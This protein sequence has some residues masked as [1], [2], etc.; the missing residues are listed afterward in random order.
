MR[1]NGFA[2]RVVAPFV[3]AAVLAGLVAV[4]PAAVAADP[5]IPPEQLSNAL[6]SA[7]IQ[8]KDPG[9][10]YERNLILSAE[11]LDWRA[12]N[13]AAS[14][15]SLDKH[16]AAVEK[17]VGTAIAPAS[18]RDPVPDVFGRSVEALYSIPEVDKGGAQLKG[19]VGALTA[20]DLKSSG[21]PDTLRGVLQQFS[22]TTSE[23]GSRVWAALREAAGR[24][25]TLNSTW[26]TRM[27]TAT[28]ADAAAVDPVAPVDDLKK[29][30]QIRKV[31]DVDAIQDAFKQGTKQGLD[32]LTKQIKPLLKVLGDPNSPNTPLGQAMEWVKKYVDPVTG[33]IIKS[34]EQAQKEFLER[35]KEF[36]GYLDKLKG[37]LMAIATIAKILNS[38]YSKDIVK[39]AE[40]LYAIGKNVV[41]LITAISA[42]TAIGAGATIGSVVPVIGTVIGA[43][44]GLVVT[45]VA[46]LGSGGGGPSPELQAIQAMHKEMRESFTQLKDF[47][48]QFQ[49]QVNVRFDQIDA[50]LNKIYGDMMV[51]FNQ[52]LV[53]IGQSNFELTQEIQTLHGEILGLAATMQSNH[54]QILDSLEDASALPFKEFVKKYIDYATRENHPIPSYGPPGDN[55]KDA[56]EKFS[57][58][59]DTLARSKVFMRQ[60][61]DAAPDDILTTNS[62][63]SSVNYLAKYAATRY[64]TQYLQDYPAEGMP[65][66]EMFAAAARAYALLMDQNGPL[67]AQEPLVTIDEKKTVAR[68]NDMLKAGGDL[69]G[70]ARRFNQPRTRPATGEW[71]ATNSLFSG[72]QADNAAKVADFAN[73]LIRLESDS[74]VMAADRRFNL[75]GDRN[76]HVDGDMKDDIAGVGN[77]VQAK[78]DQ[79]INPMPGFVT[80]DKLPATVRLLKQ[81]NPEIKLTTC[82]S[83]VRSRRD[84]TYQTRRET[85]ITIPCKFSTDPPPGC[86]KTTTDESHKMSE[87]GVEFQIWTQ[88]PGQNRTY[89]ASVVGKAEVEIC[90]YPG[91]PPDDEPW[92]K[93]SWADDSWIGCSLHPDE[94]AKRVA[95]VGYEPVAPMASWGD[96]WL[97]PFLDRQLIERRARYYRLVAGQLNDGKLASAKAIDTNMR[98]VRA[99]SEIAFP[100]ALQTDARL[101]ELLYGTRSLPSSLNTSKILGDASPLTVLFAKAAQNLDAQKD[102]MADQVVFSKAEAPGCTAAPAEVKTAD[103][104]ARCLATVAGL[105]R[106]AFGERIEFYSTDLTHNPAAQDPQTTTALMR[107]LRI[108][109]KATHPD[110][111]VESPGGPAPVP[112]GSLG[113]TVGAVGG[114]SRATLGQTHFFAWQGK[115]DEVLVASS[116]DGKQWWPPVT[117]AGPHASSDAPAI[118]VFKDKLV[119]VWRSGP[120]SWSDGN[121]DRTLAISTS[122]D[123][124]TWTPPSRLVPVTVGS[125]GISLTVLGDKLQLVFRGA[126][127]DGGKYVTSSYD[128]KNWKRPLPAVN[129]GGTS[130]APGVTALGGKLVQLWKGYGTDQRMFSATSVNGLDW[131]DQAVLANAT[132][133]GGPSPVV[134]NGKVFAVWRNG[135]NDG[136]SVSDT[137]DGAAWASPRALHA[138]AH[139]IG[140][141]SLGVV[142]GQLAAIWR[143]GVDGKRVNVSTSA[144]GITWT[145]PAP[146][147]QLSPDA[148]QRAGEALLTEAGKLWNAS[149]REGAIAKAM[150]ALAIAR[151]LAAESPAYEAVVADW[152]RSPISGYLADAG[153]HD[154]S[155]ALLDESITLYRRLA[156]RDPQNVQFKVNEADSTVWQGVRVWN[157]GDKEKG[158]DRSVEGLNLARTLVPKGPGPAAVFAQ[159]ARWP[160]SGFLADT[161]QHDQAIAVLGEAI[162]TYQNLIRQEP[163]NVQYKLNQADATIWQGVRIWNK[164]DKDKG[165]DRSVEGINLARPLISTGPGPA[166]AFAQWARSPVS[167][168]LADTGRHDEAI[169]LLGEAMTAYQKLIQQDP[170]NLQHKVNLADATIWQGIRTWNKGDHPLGLTRVL[171]GIKLARQ[172]APSG[173]VFSAHL[174]AW[175]LSPAVD[176]AEASGKHDDAI[177]MAKEAVDI[178]TRL[179]ESD[180][181]TYA[182]PLATAKQKLK[183]L[184]G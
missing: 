155:I 184:Q 83:D 133:D 148:R 60:A 10:V 134:F 117:I 1:G 6:F 56:A 159:W 169:A 114:S 177:A 156:E 49:K 67:A 142:G 130:A 152:I 28:T 75:W 61:T 116:V 22:A 158:R 82:W 92:A 77:C 107:A 74:T 84:W 69:V 136:L 20:R 91:T 151:R 180:P 172:L 139:A 97:N 87:L 54:R 166:A 174:G 9:R 99:F 42:L 95:K 125:A 65:N 112:P 132:G 121:N 145:A 7:A 2:R 40:T 46:L 147:N 57:S 48:T 126:G 111:P 120:F 11:L 124:K 70:A 16:A 38:R 144:D 26:K 44:V 31:I 93:P 64:G 165:R 150:E 94:L 43:V 90:H 128:A 137:A 66:A 45:L 85:P 52:V 115:Q 157:K 36:D 53:A 34:D 173:P 182:G 68:V 81:L 5:G 18:D 179:A 146:I 110:F 181:A 30:P 138:D 33:E 98:L 105:R 104:V 103:P 135:V 15:D 122:T 183:T 119:A 160:V 14:A 63:A 129:N 62:A 154:E 100:T 161:G 80:S 178:Y 168:F 102:A 8:L 127:T 37:G 24:D 71:V 141:P 32:A 171:D 76:Q 108:E 149:N 162:T 96:D 19:L 176:Y 41:P 23:I 25:G 21:D 140:A 175:L 131:T 167:G 88:L 78:P 164:G 51:K 50:A 12:K 73:E 55:Y 58:S 89:V 86:N 29:L 47:L 106:A 39:F 3:A 13:P 123:G 163:A 59:G 35:A 143:D 17:V 109:A 72:L 118:V 4:P 101:R 113:E 153:R 170:G 27:G 79:I